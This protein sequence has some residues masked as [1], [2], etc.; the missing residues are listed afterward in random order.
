MSDLKAN[1]LT[2]EEQMI[3]D[4]VRTERAKCRELESDPP[5]E[6][7]NIPNPFAVLTLDETQYLQDSSVFAEGN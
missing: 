5:H 6:Q 7:D 3:I 1:K 4:K 2:K